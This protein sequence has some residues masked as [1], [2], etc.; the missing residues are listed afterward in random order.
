MAVYFVVVVL[1]VSDPGDIAA[2]LSSVNQEARDRAMI[3]LELQRQRLED[4]LLDQLNVVLADPDDSH[5][6]RTHTVLQAIAS[7]RADNTVPRLVEAVAFVLDCDTFPIG[8]RPSTS[9][10]YPV[11][12]TLRTIGNRTVIT[13]ILDA[14]A[15]KDRDDRS[16]R[17]YA[18]VLIQVLGKDVARVAVDRGKIGHVPKEQ[19]RLL[20]LLKMID[21]EPLLEMPA[22]KPVGRGKRQGTPNNH[23]ISDGTG[24]MINL[25]MN[26]QRCSRSMGSVRHRGG[27]RGC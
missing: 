25:D 24:G 4:A 15:G 12:E 26:K 16:L 8:E 13:G 3:D 21:E 27:G 10:Y 22:P 23:S 7:A 9:S 18:W 6:G 2:K 1:W 19:Q 20:R 17:I 5:N 11:A 14:T